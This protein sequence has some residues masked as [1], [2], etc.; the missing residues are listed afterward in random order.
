MASYPPPNNQ[1]GT[2]F[3]PIDWIEPN[4]GSIDTA[5]LNEHYCQF[6][7]AQGSMSFAGINNTGSTTIK[8]NL[9]MTGTPNINFLEFP[10]GTKQYTAVAG[11]D[12]LND[13]NTWSGVNTFYPN[14]V[15]TYGSTMLQGITLTNNQS[16]S[17]ASGDNTIVSYSPSSGT[18][19]EIYSLASR[20]NCSGVPPQLQLKP[21]GVFSALIANGTNGVVQLNALGGT[22]SKIVLQ[23][24][25][26]V[27]LQIVPLIDFNAWGQLSATST[28]SGITSTVQLNTPS[29][30][31]GGTIGSSLLTNTNDGT[32]LNIN[33]AIT[34]G[35]IYFSISGVPYGASITP[36]TGGNL[37]IKTSQTNS[38]ITLDS[39][40][41]VVLATNP[42]I[43]FSSYGTISTNSTNTALQ[44]SADFQVKPQTSYS[45]S[46]IYG[47]LAST[48]AFVQSAIQSQ[49]SGD[50][51]LAGDNAFT[52]INTFSNFCGTSAQQT[53]PL[54]SGNQFTTTSYV[55]NLNT[56]ASSFTLSSQQASFTGSLACLLTSS[57]LYQFTTNN[58]VAFSPYS[59]N[60]DY[61]ICSSPYILTD[62]TFSASITELSTSRII[63]ANVQ[64]SFGSST[65]SYVRVNSSV[66]LG[67]GNYT[68]TFNGYAYK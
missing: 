26:G 38:N 37:T 44:S 68:L 12:I 16:T 52:G 17:T 42:T 31:I 56:I 39:T 32:G 29:I 65:F 63:S 18:G 1:Q 35:N 21:D 62:I 40:A 60:T 23:S 13:A 24:S 59:P 47:D 5:Y 49:G 22:G 64:I 45:S 28:T 14:P 61:L 25:S 9:V 67:T 34:S 19:F 66:S 20:N 7:V 33:S 57:N 46:T 10:D 6:P 2:I 58:S 55:N 27:Y 3:N 53:Y 54:P 11:G 8:Q 41:G 4:A 36:T 48:Q 50:V 43:A 51:Y 15:Q 30:K